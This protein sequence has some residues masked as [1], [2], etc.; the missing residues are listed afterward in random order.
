MRDWKKERLR[1]AGGNA[2]RSAARPFAGAPRNSVCADR[3]ADALK[4]GQWDLA[5]LKIEF[6]ELILSEAPIEI[7]GFGLVEI[8]HIPRRQDGFLH[9]AHQANVGTR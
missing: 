2:L 6:E 4:K 3:R 7:L 8:D 1:R 5:A 9:N